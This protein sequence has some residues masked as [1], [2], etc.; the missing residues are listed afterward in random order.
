MRRFLII[1]VLLVTVSFCQARKFTLMLNLEEN[2]E[3]MQ[4]SHSESTII[5]DFNGRRAIM[6]MTASGKMSYLVKKITNDGFDMEVRYKSLSISMLL[7]QQTLE[8]SSENRDEKDIFSSIL[9][10]LKDKPFGVKMTKYGEITEVR[11]IEILFES[12]FKKIPDIPE[13]Q[14]ALIKD[15]VLKAYGK[16]AFKGNVEMVTAIYPKKKAKKGNKWVVNTKLESGMSADVRTT[17]QFSDYT[18]DQFM[19]SGESKIETADKDAYLEFNG[20]P[21]K[22]DLTGT[23]TSEIKIDRETGWIVEAKIIQKIKGDTFIK[24]NPKMPE[25]MKTPMKMMTEMTI[26]NN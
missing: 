8:F 3:Y 18:E 5:Q 19:I 11:N 21:M 25:G 4:T 7:P 2:V 23:M 9:S 20:M 16:A 15:Q 17:Y 22:F 24:E 12:A 26:R 14:L 13:D 6:V 1:P 10:E